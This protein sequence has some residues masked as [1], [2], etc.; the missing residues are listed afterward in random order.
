MKQATTEVHRLSPAA[1]HAKSKRAKQAMDMCQVYNF[2]PFWHMPSCEGLLFITRLLYIFCE[3][4]GGRGESTQF[5]FLLPLLLS[6][7][8]H[9]RMG[10]G[11]LHD[12]E[13]GGLHEDIIFSQK[14]NWAMCRVQRFL[15]LS[16]PLTLSDDR[17]VLFSLPFYY[18]ASVSSH[19][20]TPGHSKIAFQAPG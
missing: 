19:Q 18:A 2:V 10:R 8:N 7:L 15:L 6:P 13:K 5:H 17:F 4:E 1:L 16:K 20:S 14:K 12:D 11:R 3:G 9:K